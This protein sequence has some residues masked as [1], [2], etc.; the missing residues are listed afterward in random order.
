VTPDPVQLSGNFR[1]K[2][3]SADDIA[4]LAGA[5]QGF[6]TLN[7]GPFAQDEYEWENQRANVLEDIA[8]GTW[9]NTAMKLNG[10]AGNIAMLG[11]LF[12]IA[13]GPQWGESGYSFSGYTSAQAQTDGS[14]ASK[15]AQNQLV[16]HQQTTL[17]FGMYCDPNSGYAEADAIS[18]FR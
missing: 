10:D 8:A 11:A 12:D 17:R 5:N 1:L 16:S 15:Y 13:N 4:C 18:D 2:T 7:A 6:A 9:Q 3:L 14:A